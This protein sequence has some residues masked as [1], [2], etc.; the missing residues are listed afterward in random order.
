MI[1]EK[2]VNLY[3]YGPWVGLAWL[4]FATTCVGLFKAR[5][6]ISND[7]L[8]LVISIIPYL[9]IFHYIHYRL[10]FVKALEVS[11][12]T[13]PLLL[14]REE[15]FQLY[16]IYWILAPRVILQVLRLILKGRESSH[17]RET[18]GEILIENKK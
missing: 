12:L 17:S 5:T 13:D 1:S 8:S 4:A 2:L 3:C 16:P 7:I 9:A 14:A 15:K 11:G 18:G 10:A 6:K